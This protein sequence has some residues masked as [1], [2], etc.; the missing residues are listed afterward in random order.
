MLKISGKAENLSLVE[1]SL[2]Q[3]LVV[4]T[5]SKVVL[6]WSLSRADHVIMHMCVGTWARLNCARAIFILG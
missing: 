3:N 4:E 5:E 6:G 2:Q 1:H